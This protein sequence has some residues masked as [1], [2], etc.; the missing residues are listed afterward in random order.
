[1]SK[2]TVKHLSTGW[3]C[4]KCNSTCLEVLGTDP[5]SADGCEGLHA[6]DEIRCATCD[7]SGHGSDIDIESESWYVRD[8][9]GD[10]SGPFDYDEAEDRVSRMDSGCLIPSSSFSG[11]SSIPKKVVHI[12]IEGGVCEVEEVPL[13]V[14]VIVRD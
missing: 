13:G 5:D 6:V 10:I 8:D 2:C 12:N 4:P 7:W 3:L 9:E 1:M 11:D 14:K